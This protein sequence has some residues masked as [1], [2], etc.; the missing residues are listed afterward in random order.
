MVS[1]PMIDARDLESGKVALTRDMF[2][3]D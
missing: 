3:A 1:Y 2:G